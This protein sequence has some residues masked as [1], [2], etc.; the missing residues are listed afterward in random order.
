LNLALENV[1]VIEYGNFICVPYCGK[2]LADLG[3]EVIKIEEPGQGDRSRKS[4]PFLNDVPRNDCGGLFLYLN[5]NKFGTTLNLES[6]AGRK[7]FKEL[8]KST[9]IL[10]EDSTPGKMSALG[11]GYGDL[12]SLNTHLVM[13]SV[14]PF[15]QT[16]PY[17]NY[18]GSDLVGWHMGGIG[19]ITPRWA[20]TA[21]KEPLSVMHMADFITSLNAAVATMCALHVQRRTGLGQHVDVS[22]LEV[23]VTAMGYFIM[24]W[25]YEH[26]NNTRVSK[27]TFAPQHFLR[28]KDGWV[29]FWAVDERPWRRLIDMMGNPEWAN[30]ELV[31]DRYFRGEHWESLQPLIEEWAMKHTKAELFQMA[32]SYEVPLGPANSISELVASTQLK[33]RDFFVE[34]EHPAAGKLTFPGAPYKLSQTPWTLRMPA[35]LIGQHNRDI[36]C[37]R[38]GHSDEELRTMYSSGVI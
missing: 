25:P 28:C 20:D 33:E 35:P 26:K 36:Y 34:T 29:F 23:V 24:S 2:L 37:G 6:M 18:K 17:K 21:E 30:E 38:L 4:G 3:A 13:T 7:I 8:I 22:Q 1:K 12:S 9:D 14:T 27:S 11:L 19:H 15:G 16:G 32:K 10:L 31:N 5:S